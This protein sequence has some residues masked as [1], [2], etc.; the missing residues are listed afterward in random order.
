[1]VAS[2]LHPEPSSP[3]LQALLKAS[4]MIPAGGAPGRQPRGPGSYVAPAGADPM[5]SAQTR[6]PA[7]A[8]ALFGVP[9]LALGHEVGVR[10]PGGGQVLQ[11][12][13]VLACECPVLMRCL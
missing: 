3:A 10:S 11:G 8:R 5:V 13:G 7:P 6:L 4:E 2:T 1:M 9:M 12:D